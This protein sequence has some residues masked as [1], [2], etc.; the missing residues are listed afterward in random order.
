[1]RLET[2]AAQVDLAQTMKGAKHTG[3]MI[4]QAIGG[5]RVVVEEEWLST[6]YPVRRHSGTLALLQIHNL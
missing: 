3:M 2:V 4:R 5:K 6:S 1:M